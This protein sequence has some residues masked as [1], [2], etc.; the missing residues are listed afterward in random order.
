MDKIRKVSLLKSDKCGFKLLHKKGDRVDFLDSL[1]DWLFNERYEDDEWYRNEI[2]GYSKLSRSQL[3][4]N[5]YY[6]AKDDDVYLKARIIVVY[7]NGES[8]TFYYDN[9]D[10]A[11]RAYNIICMQI[12][13]FQI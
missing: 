12:N 8:E 4:N 9:D 6:Y 13:L 3:K 7:I 1:I 2:I 5:K 10:E 11:E